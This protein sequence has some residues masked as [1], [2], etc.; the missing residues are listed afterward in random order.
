VHPHVR[1]FGFVGRTV[2]P[3]DDAE[4]AT[5]VEFDCGGVRLEDPQ[6]QT[7][8]VPHG[9]GQELGA[10]ATP[11]EVECDVKL[12]HPPARERDKPGHGPAHFRNPEFI[13]RQQRAAQV[14]AVF[15]GPVEVTE[16]PQPVLPRGAPDPHEF[17]NEVRVR[18]KRACQA[19]SGRHRARTRRD[20]NLGYE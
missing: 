16:K 4:T 18:G 10:D 3:F 7:R 13:V 12:V 8:A 19:I 1:P 15:V 14:G 9:D 5:F 17:R 2:G 6:L 20:C 11:L